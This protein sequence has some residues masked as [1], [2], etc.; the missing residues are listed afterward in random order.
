MSAKL[1]EV[2]GVVD[3]LAVLERESF[4]ILFTTDLRDQFTLEKAVLLN[5][6]D[7]SNKQVYIAKVI[8]EGKSLLIIS[9]TLTY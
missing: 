1:K 9:D 3:N 7:Y 6:K 2:I 4:E 8:K 5:L